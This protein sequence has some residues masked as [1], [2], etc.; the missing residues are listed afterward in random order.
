MTN[1]NRFR[2]HSNSGLSRAGLA[3]ILSG[4]L[5]MAFLPTPAPA[6]V[7]YTLRADTATL[8]MP[9]T[10]EM[11]TM[12]GFALGSNAV[13]VPGPTLVVPPGETTLQI[14]LTNNLSIPV[15]IVIHGLAT[16]MSPTWIG[17]RVRSFTAET[18]PGASATY[19][20]TNVKPGTYLY[21][22]G[23]N[24]AVQVQMGLYG[25]VKKDYSAKQAYTSPGTAYDSE[26]I[27]F[28]SEIDPAFHAVVAAGQYGTL[29]TSTI[30]YQPQ[31]FLINGRPYTTGAAPV[32]L[33]TGRSLLRFL[34]AG[35]QTH[36]PL[37]Q[38]SYLKIYAEDGN[39]YP[40]AREQ[41]SL[42]LPAGKTMDA[43]IQVTAI[44]TIPLY[45]RRLFLTNSNK[46]GGG[47]LTN[48]QFGSLLYFPLILKN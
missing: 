22:S 12:W 36:V 20:W 5:W 32:A 26:A 34:N 1:L 24:P 14:N 31:Y 42:I 21:Q 10:G 17:G 4:L 40:Y 45:D 6:A 28:F 7:V 39:L 37:L 23:T 38:G 46:P 47:M 25:A 27:L 16:A 41:Y 18:A 48:L 3:L 35:L 2:L 19:T 9:D 8:T 11:V 44:G 29:V 15:S 30:D 13:S 43:I 33:G